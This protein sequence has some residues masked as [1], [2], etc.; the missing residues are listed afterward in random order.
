MI[1][2]TSKT[3]VGKKFIVM[4]ENDEIKTEEKIS[5]NITNAYTTFEGR[6]NRLAFCVMGLKAFAVFFVICVI[7]GFLFSFS[8][9]VGYV[10]L[11]F[12]M[13]AITICNISLS[14]RRL[15]DLNRSG[16]WAILLFVPWIDLVAALYVIFA[17]GTVG[18]NDYGEDPLEQ[19]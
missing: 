18:R 3:A 6:L 5:K 10:L 15:H 13:L 11:G 4:L 17:P 14:V 1:Y 9:T 12:A 19:S 2:I 7:A 8:E 16:W